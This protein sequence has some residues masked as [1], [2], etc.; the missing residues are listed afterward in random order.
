MFQAP[1]PFFFLETHRLGLCSD[2]LWERPR[3][4]SL[5][6]N[7]L[8]FSRQFE[9]RVAFENRALTVTGKSKIMSYPL[10]LDAPG[11]SSHFSVLCILTCK[12]VLGVILSDGLPV[13]ETL[14]WWLQ[15]RLCSK[16]PLMLEVRELPGLCSCQLLPAEEL[17]RVNVKHPEL[18]QT[19]CKTYLL[20]MGPGWEYL[21]PQ[22]WQIP[23]IGASPPTV[24]RELLSKTRL[25][26]AI[27][28][29]LSIPASLENT[30]KEKCLSF[31][32]SQF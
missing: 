3:K 5:T 24:S 30:D 22:N 25:P 27:Q 7:F 13:T 23:Q 15:S 2:F 12:L 16:C 20:E 17:G 21:L 6:W 9:H 31:L 1:P 28:V 11:K 26:Q 8:T 19:G 14:D 10:P 29:N 32:Y 18:L 4:R